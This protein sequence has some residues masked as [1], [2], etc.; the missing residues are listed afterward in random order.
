MSSIKK[1]AGQ[2]AIYGLPSILGRLLNFLLVPLH[3]SAMTRGEFGI[4]TDLYSQIAVL[5]VLLT[6]G[7]ETSFFNYASESKSASKAF[8]AGMRALVFTTLCFYLLFEIFRSPISEILR[9]EDHPEYL[10]MMFL[11]LCMD[12]L[13]ALPFAKLRYEERAIRFVIVKMSLIGVFILINV[14]FFLVVPHWP[15]FFDYWPALQKV[16]RVSAV[17]ISNV[18]ASSVMLIMLLPEWRIKGGWKKDSPLLK[19]MIGYG[20]P[21]M[22]AGLAGIANELADRQFLK[23]LLPEETSLEQLGVYGAVYKLSIFLMLFV[24]AYRYAM[25][26][27]FFRLKSESSSGETNAQVLRL[28]TAIL[29]LAL[30][31]LNAAMPVLKGFI[32]EKFWIGLSIAP[33]LFAANYILGINTHL[34]IWYKLAGRTYF[35]LVITLTGLVVTVGLNIWLIPK[36]GIMASAIATLCSYACSMGL[37]LYL[38]NKYAPLPYQWKHLSIYFFGSLLLGFFAWKMQE[39]MGLWALAALVP[40]LIVLY[41]LEQKSIQLLWKKVR[42]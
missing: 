5:I 3:T 22:L 18:V 23:Y 36:Y 14:F 21:L 6:Y 37:N 39:K 24:Q 34:S 7:M 10:R 29:G 17:L 42:A 27:F 11:V 40:Y 19:K 12:V 8:G 9:Y 30:I 2:T 41:L 20:I 32:D 26:P 16:D 28:F 13:S 25:E 31:F 1:L 4:I 38:G 33:L 15:I 35:A